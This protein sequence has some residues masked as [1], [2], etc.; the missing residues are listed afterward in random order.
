MTAAVA[1]LALWFVAVDWH[2]STFVVD[3][4]HESMVSCVE[5][6]RVFDAEGFTTSECY[7]ERR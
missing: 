6:R 4:P 2:L 3:G 5:S 7:A 1:A